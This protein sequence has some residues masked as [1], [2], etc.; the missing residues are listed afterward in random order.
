MWHRKKERGAAMKE[1]SLTQG[2]VA[3]VD[4]EDFET[5]SRHRWATLKTRNTCYAM[6]KSGPKFILMHREILGLQ[7]GDGVKSDHWDGNGL[8]NQRV[9][10]RRCTSLQNS[11]NQRVRVGTKHSR[12]KGVSWK[13]DLQKCWIALITINKRTTYLGYF[14][15][16][17]AAA[18][19]YN[20]AAQRHFGEF[21]RLNVLERTM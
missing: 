10:L 2:K 7:P 16:E 9:N 18:L 14:H 17:E 21:A 20:F 12:F 15:T 6:R 13:P 11:R 19:A 1:I 8:N 4:D 3:L 5:V